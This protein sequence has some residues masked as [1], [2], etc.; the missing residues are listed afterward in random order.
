MA[1]RPNAI[2][3]TDSPIVSAQEYDVRDL[4]A[5]RGSL[6]VCRCCDRKVESCIGALFIVESVYSIP[7]CR[8]LFL[9]IYRETLTVFIM[10][11]L[12]IY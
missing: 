4:S 8:S 11:I 12:W 3:S 7:Y 10:H 2:L 1:C 5:Q 6:E 9:D